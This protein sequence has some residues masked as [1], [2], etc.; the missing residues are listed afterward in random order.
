MRELLPAAQLG[1]H[2]EKDDWSVPT[3]LL[4]KRKPDTPLAI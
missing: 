3:I 4:T 1:M 2:A